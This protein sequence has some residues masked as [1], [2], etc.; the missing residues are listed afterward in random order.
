M[1]K[2]TIGEVG[3]DIK[4]LKTCSETRTAIERL[5]VFAVC[6]AFAGWLIDTILQ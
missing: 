2:R 1:A 3:T 5:A 6:C 4:S